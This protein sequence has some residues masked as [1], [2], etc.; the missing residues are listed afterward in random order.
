MLP[1]LTT[2][3]P[4]GACRKGSPGDYQGVAIVE[5]LDKTTVGRTH[6]D[7]DQLLGKLYTHCYSHLCFPEPDLGSAIHKCDLDFAE[8]DCYMVVAWK[9]PVTEDQGLH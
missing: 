9:S 8:V 7:Y 3:H 2:T 4:G 6:S 5:N 1:P